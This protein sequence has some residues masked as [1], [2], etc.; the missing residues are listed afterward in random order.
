MTNANGSSAKYVYGV[1]RTSRASPPKAIGINDEP[2]ALVK[3]DGVAALTSDVPG[4]FLEAGREELLTHSRV[5]EGALEDG[6]VLPMRF[7]VVMPGE[8]SVR[9]ELLTHSRVLEQALQGGVVLP[10]RFGVVMPDEESVRDQLLSPHREKLEAQLDEMDGKVEINI[11][12]IYD[13]GAILREVLAHSS[14]AAKLRQAIRGKP[15]D[16]TYY[17]RIRLGEVVAQELDLKRAEDERA[18][19]DRMLAHAAAVEVGELVHER[20]AVNASFLVERTGLQGFDR[21]IDELG[22]EQA[23][24]IRLRYTGPLPPHSFVELTMEG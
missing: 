1:V 19:V 17:E 24:R 2:I 13:E 8:E 18:I 10:M 16:A 5:L 3:A 15:E 12:G 21:A 4:E 20:M 14:E 7:G 11:K 23:G 9:D 6:T 22:E